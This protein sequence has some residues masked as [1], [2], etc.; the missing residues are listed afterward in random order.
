MD[1]N[2]RRLPVAAADMYSSKALVRSAFFGS[3][4]FG[5]MRLRFIRRAA[6]GS[7]TGEVAA[8]RLRGVP[9]TLRASPKTLIRSQ[10]ANWLPTRK[11]P[12]PSR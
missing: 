2:E 5:S 12:Q 3:N 1:R 9:I 10:P 8:L 11:R 6:R 7:D 4:W